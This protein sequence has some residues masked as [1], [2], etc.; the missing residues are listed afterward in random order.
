MFARIF[1][2]LGSMCWLWL[3]LCLPATQC[4][5]E[6]LRVT[7]WNLQAPPIGPKSAGTAA[8][9]QKQ[10]GL[11][12]AAAVLKKLAPDVILLQQVQD[13][14]TCEQL[15]GALK[16]ADYR[17]LACSAFPGATAGGAGSQ[18][19]AILA[20]QRGYFSWSQAWKPEGAVA[21]PGGFA[22]AAIEA[23]GQRLGFFSVESKGEQPSAPQLLSQVA[24]IR[25]WVTNRVQVFVAGGTFGAD[26]SHGLEGAGFGDVF[27]DASADGRVG[28]PRNS[29]PPGG[30]SD[31]MFAL[32]PQ[33]ATNSLISS[34]A[35]AV[36]YPVT[37]DLDLDPASIAAAWAAHTEAMA[38]R[39]RPSG[40]LTPKAA[41]V[42][43][44]RS[45]LL[46]LLV[47]VLALGGVLALIALVWVIA[48]RTRAFEPRPP[49]LLVA[50]EEN[51]AAAASLF[52]VVRTQSVTGSAPPGTAAPPT[53]PPIVHIEVA[54]ATQTHAEI[55]RRR[56]HAAEQRAARATAAMRSG[57]I[58]DLTRWLKQKLLRKLITDRAELLEAQR[59]ATAK[60]ITVEERLARLERQIQQQNQGYQQRI[61]HLTRELLA[62]KEENRELIR[63]QIRQVKAEME[64]ARA[65]LLAQ[66]NEDERP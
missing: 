64:A 61:E 62:A 24:S 36:H 32:P 28:R 51:G 23:H 55:L 31:H 5:A 16:P 20:R 37:C 52:T 56:A 59:A 57:L 6:T 38:S 50:G 3:A 44:Q 66:A 1:Q 60:A 47:A 54:G 53:P 19:V 65:R 10:V 63:A 29:Q 35:G 22:L 13:W 9:D 40:P 45:L 21:M 30:L 33:C 46:P 42:S 39:E 25:D 27:L 58:R 7:T 8:P 48:R 4:V 15:A 11:P 2:V 26:T 41:D 43:L 49:R 14:K 18:Q 34:S 17:V 12:E